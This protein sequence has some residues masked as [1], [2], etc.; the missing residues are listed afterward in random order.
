MEDDN[1]LNN[2]A[3]GL[4]WARKPS[5]VVV[6]QLFRLF[7]EAIESCCEMYSLRERRWDKFAPLKGSV[8]IEQYAATL[9]KETKSLYWVAARG[10]KQG[11]HVILKLNMEN[12]IFSELPH[13]LWKKE[14]QG[15]SRAS[16]TP[17]PNINY[18]TPKGAI[19]LV[20]LLLRMLAFCFYRI[21]SIV[22]Q[23]SRKKAIIR[24][25]KETRE[26]APT[27]D[28]REWCEGDSTFSLILLLSKP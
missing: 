11:C 6:I 20:S 7:H 1:T 14:N 12:M 8:R 18:I 25:S 24:K 17:F 19:S 26:I 16:F 21:W 28:V 15:E 22:R 3:Y 23:I 4:G 9:H 2:F 10:N 13:W 27:V 5:E